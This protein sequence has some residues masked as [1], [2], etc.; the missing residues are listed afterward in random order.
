MSKKQFEDKKKKQRKKAF[1]L[2]LLYLV[3]SHH[4]KNTH[5][6]ILCIDKHTS[7]W[8]TLTLQW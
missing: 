5:T 7:G 4:I 6:H 8:L 3:A 1:F 2:Y